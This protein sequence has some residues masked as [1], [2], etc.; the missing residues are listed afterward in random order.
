M[1]TAPQTDQGTSPTFLTLITAGLTEVKHAVT[2]LSRDL[3]GV[4]SRM[5]TEYVPR[6]EIER[7]MDE[8]IIDIGAEKAARENDVKSLK[9]ATEKA[10]NERRTHMRWLIGP[11]AATVMSGIG[12]LS[13]VFLHFQ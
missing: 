11:G 13:G 4:L 6:R 8:L 10:Q 7:R 2:A 12:V 5:P 3:N 9:E 1:S